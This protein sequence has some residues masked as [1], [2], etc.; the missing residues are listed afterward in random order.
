MGDPG[1]NRASVALILA[2]LVGVVVSVA[3]LV[4]DAREA[5][6]A[7]PT[8]TPSRRPFVSVPL[9]SPSSV[10]RDGTEYVVKLLTPLE[11][12]ADLEDGRVLLVHVYDEY[13]VYEPRCSTFDT[14]ARVVEETEVDVT[15]A[16]FGYALPVVPEGTQ[17]ASIGGVGED[18]HVLRLRLQAPLGFRRVID[19]RTG[20]AFGPS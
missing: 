5:E 1:L 15:I 7:A 19:A 12:E 14:S 17:C 6:V 9:P 13:S 18:D 4:A 20:E 3:L 2:T 8:T 11:V 16:T 10:V